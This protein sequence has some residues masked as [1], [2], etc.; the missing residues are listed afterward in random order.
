MLDILQTA[1]LLDRLKGLS[2]FNLVGLTQS[3]KGHK[4][5]SNSISFIVDIFFD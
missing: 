3:H 5:D 2:P 1:Q 4:E